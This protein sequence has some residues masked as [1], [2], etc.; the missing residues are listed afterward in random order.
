MYEISESSATTF[1][2]TQG[3]QDSV[4]ILLLTVSNF[5]CVVARNEKAG[6]F[7]SLIIEKNH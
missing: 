5:A 2:E 4:E 1:A 6:F 3:L 7:F